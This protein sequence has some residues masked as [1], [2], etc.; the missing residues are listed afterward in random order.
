MIKNLPEPIA[1]YF[2]YKTEDGLN[3]APDFLSPDATVI[4]TGEDT[5]VNGRDAILRW[6]AQV[7]DQYKFTTELL[8]LVE[9]EGATVVTTLASGDF[10]G[11][12]AEFAYRFELRDG[13]ISRLTIDFVGFR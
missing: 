6:M 5:E 11:S 2:R 10:P 8:G 7:A 12:P 3:G 4:D 1:A 9:E 13:L